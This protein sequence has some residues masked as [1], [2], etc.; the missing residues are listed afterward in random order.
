MTS[1]NNER[2]ILLLLSLGG[3][4]LSI[5]SVLL[6]WEFWVPPII[7]LGIISIWAMNITGN[8]E[9]KVRKVAYFAYTMLIIFYHGAHRTSYYDVAL[10]MV[11]A[12][13][14]MSF[15]DDVYMM[16]LLLAE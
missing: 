12:L 2:F 8:P 16:N 1:T 11:F 13:T 10:V 5:E 15:M 4:G 9:Y 14:V 6:H 7:I 3:I